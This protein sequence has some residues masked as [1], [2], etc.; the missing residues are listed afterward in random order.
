MVFLTRARGS[1]MDPFSGP[2]PP[3]RI[4][5]CKALHL[6]DLRTSYIIYYG[7]FK[8]F[9]ADR[10]Y[11]YIHISGQSLAILIPSHDR[12]LFNP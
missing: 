7:I 6:I 5:H 8:H 1:Y 3:L 11:G 4:K 9:Y 2:P 12:Q 10:L